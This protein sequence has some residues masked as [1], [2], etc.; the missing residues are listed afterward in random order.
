MLLEDFRD[1]WPW[2]V[3]RGRTLPARWVDEV[4]ADESVASLEALL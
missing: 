3:R 2:L 4:A 1:L